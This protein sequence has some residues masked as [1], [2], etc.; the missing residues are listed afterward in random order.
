MKKLLLLFFILP[1]FSHSQYFSGEIVYE[2]EIIPKS[3]TIDLTE[4]IDSKRQTTSKYI[5][6]AKQY[7][8][9]NFT[10]GNYNYSYTY[11]DET[12]RMYDDYADKPYVTYRDSRK[13]NVK[14]FSSKIFKDSIITILGHRS[15]MVET[16]SDFGKMKTY[17]SDDVRVNP[18]DFKGHRVGNWYNKLKEV[19]G[20]ISLKTISEYENYYEIMEAVK[21]EER[22]VKGIEFALPD[23]PIGASFSALDSQVEMKQPS[24]EQ[25][26]CYQRKVG[27]VSKING[28]KFTSYITFLLLKNGTIKFIEPYEKDIHSF[29]KVGL[30]IITNCGFEFN[31]GK[32]SDELVDS[33]VYV[34]I[35]FKK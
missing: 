18:A 15:Y 5:I 11:D 22:K 26:K 21:I 19:N 32:I 27:N 4:L 28:E 23:K 20:A 7:K 34:P 31:P 8:A 1:F 33:E 35:G 14:Y 17:Y 24:E 25:I 30:D 9:T 29:Y 12:K 10:N 16:E 13:A 3:D 2:R 6:T